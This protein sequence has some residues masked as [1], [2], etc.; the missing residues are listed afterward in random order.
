M[1]SRREV[2]HPPPRLREPEPVHGPWLPRQTRNLLLFFASCA[3]TCAQA[4]IRYS[5]RLSRWSA[6]FRRVR[7]QGSLPQRVVAPVSSARVRAALDDAVNP[8]RGAS[9]ARRCGAPS[10]WDTNLSPAID[11][12]ASAALATAAG[13]CCLC[14]SPRTAAFARRTWARFRRASRS[15]CATLPPPPSPSPPLLRRPNAAALA[16]ALAVRGGSV[17]RRARRPRSAAARI[18]APRRCGGARPETDAAD[19]RPAPRALRRRPPDRRGRGGGTLVSVVP[20][21]LAGPRRRR[22]RPYRRPCR[23]LHR[24][25]PLR[26]YSPSSANLVLWT[27]LGVV[28]TP[29]TRSFAS[30]ERAVSSVVS[31]ARPLVRRL[32]RRL[33]R[34]SLNDRVDSSDVFAVFH[35]SRPGPR[36]GR[37]PVQPG[38]TRDPGRRRPRPQRRRPWLRH[39][40]SPSPSRLR[41]RRRARTPPPTISRALLRNV[42]PSP[43]RERSIGTPAP[44]IAPPR[45]A[46][47]DASSRSPRAR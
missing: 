25:I 20:V 14:K 37:P 31:F 13:L 32:V 9:C 47:A 22:R 4:P 33:V 3:R 43:S 27:R 12:A 46:A 34:L 2:P 26:L 29:P 41:C 19:P 8:P 24:R 7:K 17:C 42:S 45:T 1:G 16:A 36:L 39:T 15:G 11:G 28:G 40:T 21:V 5:A 30:S 35:R 23:R 38:G 6:R 10:R 18:R 44:T